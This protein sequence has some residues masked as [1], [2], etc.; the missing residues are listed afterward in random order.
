MASSGQLKCYDMFPGFSP[1]IFEGILALSG[2]VKLVSIK[3]VI[4]SAT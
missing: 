4:Q 1:E 2:V 3:N